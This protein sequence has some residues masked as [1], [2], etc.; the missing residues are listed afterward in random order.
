MQ[1]TLCLDFSNSGL[2]C[3]VPSSFGAVRSVPGHLLLEWP[4]KPR[5]IQ[6]LCKRLFRNPLH[7]LLG[8]TALE[9]GGLSGAKSGVLRP[10]MVPD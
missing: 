8:L 6:G 9:R 5:D 3:S 7:V 2:I 4:C 1:I 10:L